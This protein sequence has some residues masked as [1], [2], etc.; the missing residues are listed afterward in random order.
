MPLVAFTEAYVLLL[1]GNDV[2]TFIESLSTNHVE[3]LQEGESI[4]TVFTKPNA[5]IIDVVALHHLGSM[6][7]MI[8]YSRN[9]QPL[10]EHLTPRTLSQDVKI[11]NIT[12]L[13]QVHIGFGEFTKPSASTEIE[14]NGYSLLVTPINSD[15]LVSEESWDEFRIENMIP[16]FGNE[17]S[18]SIHPLACG[19]DRLVH[20][21]KGCYVG[22]E[23]IARM[24]SR[25]RQ[26]K[27]LVRISN[28]QVNK[29]EVTTRGVTNSLVIRRTQ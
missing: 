29:E 10:M 28:A 15:V 9:L 20:H 27:E 7:A 24:R 14:C 26:G 23:V 6:V 2:L 5:Q 1:E 4:Q 11:R 3:Q 18:D 19:L 21:S 25:G 13:N 17:I 22:Q 12:K 16:W 8:G